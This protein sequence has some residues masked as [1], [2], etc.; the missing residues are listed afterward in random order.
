MAL[1]T[2]QFFKAHLLFA[3]LSAV[4]LTLGTTPLSYAQDVPTPTPPAD[5]GTFEGA[6]DP[7]PGPDIELPA[8]EAEPT[9]DAL[10]VGAPET[11][12]PADLPINQESDAPETDV[13]SE[14]SDEAAPLPDEAEPLPVGDEPTDPDVADP[15]NDVESETEAEPA[16]IEAEPETNSA[17]A[18][19]SPRGLW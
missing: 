3:T 2:H 19:N 18:N 6:P 11:P 16:T 5:G 4:G 7:T 15:G 9:T 17:P 10:P 13:L 14:E 1:F 12:A 8:D